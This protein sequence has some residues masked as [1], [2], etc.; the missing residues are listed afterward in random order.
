MAGRQIRWQSVGR[1]AAVVAAVIAGI[2]SLPALLGSDKPPPVPADVGLVAP[3]APPVPA[4][5][6]TATS[7]PPGPPA[8]QR[9][10]HR[11]A[12]R[13]P[14]RERSRPHR[15]R[16]H[17]RRKRSHLHSRRHSHRPDVT[18]APVTTATYAPPVYSYIPPPAPDDFGIER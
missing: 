9:S 18:P 7:P 14:A 4:P 3:S 8:P 15:E 10:R 17:P 6:P 1:A 12:K 11:L 13:N 2:V 16:S 5:P